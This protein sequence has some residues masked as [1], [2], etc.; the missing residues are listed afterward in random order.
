MNHGS[1]NIKKPLSG[2]LRSIGR[3][4]WLLCALL[5]LCSPAQTYAVDLASQYETNYFMAHVQ[6]E[7][8][9]LSSEFTNPPAQTGSADVSAAIV[10]PAIPAAALLVACGF[11]SVSAVKD[12]K[13][14]LI[15]ALTILWLIY[16]AI[17]LIC[18]V[19]RQL[20]E[21]RQLRAKSAIIQTNSSWFTQTQPA[22]KRGSSAAHCAKPGQVANYPDTIDTA[23]KPDT[24]PFIRYFHSQSLGRAPP[25]RGYCRR[26][27]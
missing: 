3:T 4:P 1:K 24:K 27:A 17:G 23:A 6:T 20:S 10:L 9:A 26:F 16:I 15:A 22:V 11:V 7:L 18:P 2:N 14:Y 12:Y 21:K 5:M 25:P 8:A 19:L 13:V